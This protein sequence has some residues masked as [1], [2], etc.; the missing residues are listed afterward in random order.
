MSDDKSSW[1]ENAFGFVIDTARQG[2]QSVEDTASSAVQAVTDT[3]SSV[4]QSVEVAASTAVQKVEDA[5][6]G[7]LQEAKSAA[8]TVMDYQKGVAEGV[9]TGVKDL[10]S[11]AQ[12]AVDMADGVALA[13]GAATLAHAAVD[14]DARKQL[15]KDLDDDWNKAKG[16]E[17][18]VG[19]AVIDPQGTGEK[20]GKQIRAGYDQAAATGHGAE[21]IGKGVGQAAVVVASM[22]VGAGEAEAAGLVAEGA[23]AASVAAEGVEAAGAVG[24]AG[25]AVA[26]AGV[27]AADASGTAA[28]AADVVIDAGAYASREAGA[29]VGD[30]G[31]AAGEA[32]GDTS[33]GSDTVLEPPLDPAAPKAQVPRSPSDPRATR[34]LG[35]IAQHDQQGLALRDAAGA[36]KSESEHI[37]SRANIVEQTRNPAT[38]ISPFDKSAYRQATTFKLG[39]ETALEKTIGDNAAARALANSGGAPTAQMLEESGLEAAIDRTLAAAQTTGDASVTAEGVDLAAHGELGTV[40]DVGTTDVRAVMQGASD[41]EI[42]AAL[43]DIENATI[44]SRFAAPKGMGLLL[45]GSAPAAN[46]AGGGAA[47]SDAAA[48]AVEQHLSEASAIVDSAAGDAASGA[49]EPPLSHP[50]V[51]VSVDPPPGRAA[52]AESSSSTRPRLRVADDLQEA[53]LEEELESVDTLP[54]QA[55]RA[56]SDDRRK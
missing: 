44:D 42:D 11:M 16:V 3:A 54:R 46:A 50:R 25:A 27:A 14:E 28:R 49:A 31:E 48:G 9:W 56:T 4:V 40:F 51:R 38:G 30:A 22:A 21:F 33:A 24:N 43:G 55:R 29:V 8:S 36:R 10:A 35:N 15:G 45:R 12:T 17:S 47:A 37:L 5:A 34:P 2:V 39:R 19:N 6:P 53:E 13:K 20:I 32:M 18:F 52:S 23:E 26:D 1:L 7:V 41:T